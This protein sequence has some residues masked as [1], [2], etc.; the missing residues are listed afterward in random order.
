MNPILSEMI[1]ELTQVMENLEIHHPERD[2]DWMTPE[3]LRHVLRL[4]LGVLT[5]VEDSR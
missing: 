4:I 3:S 2:G 5:A 1:A